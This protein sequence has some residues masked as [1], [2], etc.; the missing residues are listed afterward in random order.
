[1]TFSDN[2]DVVALETLAEP[3]SS[4]ATVSSLVEVSTPVTVSWLPE[5]RCSSKSAGIPTSTGQIGNRNQFFVFL[6]AQSISSN[7][8][9]FLPALCN[10]SSPGF[11]IQ[12]RRQC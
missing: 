3:H 10:L 6:V 8:V 1:M 11:S 12:G 4:A 2:P 9:P 5:W 7:D